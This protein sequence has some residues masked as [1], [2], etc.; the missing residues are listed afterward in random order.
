FRS[1]KDLKRYLE[2]TE[3]RRKIEDFDFSKVQKS[4]VKEPTKLE[5]LKEKKS[6]SSKQSESADDKDDETVSG[7]NH[8][9]KTVVTK[10]G[11]QIRPSC[12]LNPKLYQF[13]QSSE[14]G[15]LHV[16]RKT[17]GEMA[18]P[19]MWEFFRRY[20]NAEVTRNASPKPIAELMR[21]IGLNEKR[22]KTLIR[23]SEEFLSRDWTYADT[24]Y[25]IGKYGSDS[26]RIFHLGE[27]KDVQPDDH[28]LNKYH[29]WLWKQERAGLLD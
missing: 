1:K 10:S 17:S 13:S 22:A 12:K 24:L 21:P 9:A 4:A 19:I 5:N 3:S 8:D 14:H 29:D 6:G 28:M 7:S 26:Y 2:S 11:R 15:P 25:G 16:S 20:P 27:W 23:F 18:I